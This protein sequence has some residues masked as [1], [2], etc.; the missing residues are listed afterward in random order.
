M[1]AVSLPVTRPAGRALIVGGDSCRDEPVNLLRQQG[2]QCEEAGDPYAAMAELTGHPS[3]YKALVLSL[4]GVYREELQ[5]IA[6][7]KRH[8]PA[9]E[10][11]L[12]HADGRMAALAEA[13]RFGADGLL[14]EDGFHR[15]SASAAESARSSEASA[16]APIS[17]PI[18]PPLT[19]DEAGESERME[20]RA[21]DSDTEADAHGEP[22]LSAEELRA[23]LQEHP[24]C[25]PGPEQG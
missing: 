16:A 20:S 14:S 5:M 4:S 17:S 15:T 24:S 3:A 19:R 6:A 13:M 7:V 25:P 21:D 11:W 8:F 2:F 12:T 10:I 22:V 1:S 23:L 9:V 18:S